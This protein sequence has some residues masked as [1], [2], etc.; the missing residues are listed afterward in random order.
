MRSRIDG[1]G[2]DRPASFDEDVEPV[3]AKF[4]DKEDGFGLSQ[5]F[6]ARDLNQT[7][8]IG[9]DPRYNVFDGQLVSAV[10]CIFGVAPRTA[11]WT[12]RQPNEDAGLP[13]VRRLALNAVKDLRD[14]YH[15]QFTTGQPR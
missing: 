5:R 15:A 6:A 12:A 13:G 3:I 1:S 9:L 2:I 11:Q 7:A 10:E 8:T 14:A 4:R